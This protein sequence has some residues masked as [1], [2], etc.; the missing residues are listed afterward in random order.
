MYWIEKGRLRREEEKKVLLAMSEVEAMEK[1]A[2]IWYQR[3][4]YLREIEADE[5]IRDL[6]R[7]NPLTPM[8]G[9]KTKQKK[10]YTD[11]PFKNIY[12]RD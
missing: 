10:N 7:R 9:V 2:P 11:K 5:Y 6:R 1:G 8:S 3:M 4:R 12:E